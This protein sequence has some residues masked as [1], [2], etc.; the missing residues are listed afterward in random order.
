[1]KISTLL[2]AI[3]AF[4]IWKWI[5]SRQFK[6]QR[7]KVIAALVMA[8]F[9]VPAVHVFL[10]IKQIV[11]DCSY[12]R[13]KFDKAIWISDAEN[14][15][16]MA[17]DLIDSGMLIGKTK[18]EVKEILGEGTERNWD[19]KDLLEYYLGVIPCPFAMDPYILSVEFKD[20]RVVEVVQFEG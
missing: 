18:F 12:G 8:V 9:T 2:I 17:N 20:Q 3:P 19:N 1:M 14:R 10:I 6:T 16:L 13:V 4:F 5:F 11:S 7:A 15:Y